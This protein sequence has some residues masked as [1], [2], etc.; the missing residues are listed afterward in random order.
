MLVR[1]YLFDWWVVQYPEFEKY[2]PATAQEEAANYLRNNP[3]VV[4]KGVGMAVDQARKNPD[5]AKAVSLT[6]APPVVLVLVL[7]IAS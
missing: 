3:Q 5:L 7:V 6:K 4:Q 1:I 2:R